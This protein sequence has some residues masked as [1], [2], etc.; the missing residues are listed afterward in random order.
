MVKNQHYIKKGNFLVVNMERNQKVHKLLTTKSEAI[1]IGKKM[2]ISQ[3]FD[4]MNYD[5]NNQIR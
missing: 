2:S 5:R 3:Q 4:L 1:E